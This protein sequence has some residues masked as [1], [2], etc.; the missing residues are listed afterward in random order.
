MFEEDASSSVGF[1]AARL[2][3][4]DRLCLVVEDDRFEEDLCLDDDR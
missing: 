3:D 1:A 2:R 4:E